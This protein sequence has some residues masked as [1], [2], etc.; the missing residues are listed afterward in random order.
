MR[1]GARRGRYKYRT[2]QASR[3]DAVTILTVYLVALFGIESR[4]GVPGL[5]GAGHPSL[6]LAGL[7]FAWWVYHHIQRPEPS[8][9]GRRPVRIALLLM[10]AAFMASLTAAL[11]RPIAGA[12]TSTVQLGMVTVVAWLGVALLA[13]DGV[14]NRDRFEQLIRRLV[15]LSACLAAL[16]IAQFL[17][18]DTLVR[19][20]KIP[21]LAANITLNELGTRNG[22]VR[23]SGTAL[24]PIEFGAVLTTVLPLAITWARHDT[25][26]SAVVRWA[27]TFLMGLGIVVSISRSALICG[28][29]GLAVMAA[30][31]PP[32]SRRMLVAAVVFLVAFVAVTIPGMLG[33]LQGLFV[34]AGDDD[35]VASR[36]G[37][38]PIATEFFGTS[39]LFGRGYSTFLPA[40]RIFDNQYLL[41]LIEVGAV[42][43]VAFLGV[44]VT[45]AWSARRAR[46]LAT[47]VPMREYAQALVAAVCAGGVG[48]A[49]FD[50]LSFTMSTGVLFLVVGLSGAALRLVRD[51][52][53]APPGGPDEPDRASA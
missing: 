29:V 3:L 16:G 42:G 8:G 12:E 43:L 17:T 46:V 38:Y 52:S 31:W 27:P 32:R 40:Y 39:P 24:H 53:S 23:P 19:Y 48:L 13:N 37:S 44:L 7:G 21:G 2:A 26:F 20:I 15:F 49:L 10:L 1:A 18:D 5:G 6:L 11:S 35:S 4:L 41:L 25:R 47:D 22:F 34:G 14:P 33:S 9:G 30:I 28:V 50:G 45:A 51:P 36:T